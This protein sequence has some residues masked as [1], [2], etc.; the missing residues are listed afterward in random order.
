MGYRATFL[1]ALSV[2]MLGSVGVALIPMMTGPLDAIPFLD[3]YRWAIITRV[4][5][6]VGAGA[7]IPIS[8][9]ALKHS[10]VRV[11]ASLRSAWWARPL[12]PAACSGPCGPARS[13]IGSV[14]NTRSGRTSRFH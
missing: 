8:L 2:F 13:P 1:L 4:I 11:D 12:K 5:Q 9:A 7:V 6:S 14:G 3:Q 10:L